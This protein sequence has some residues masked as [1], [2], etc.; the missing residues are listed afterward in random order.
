MHTIFIAVYRTQFN[1]EMNMKFVGNAR[2]LTWCSLYSSTAHTKSS[3]SKVSHPITVYIFISFIQNSH[4]FLDHCITHGMFFKN[5][6]RCLNFIWFNFPCVQERITDLI[7]HVEGS[8]ILLN[9]LLNRT[10]MVTHCSN[11]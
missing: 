8:S 2:R 6:I 11:L 7:L 3:F 1:E 9:N 4:P 10:T 5:T